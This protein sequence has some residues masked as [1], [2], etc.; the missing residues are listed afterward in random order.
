MLMR[1][2]RCGFLVIFGVAG[3]FLLGVP[4]SGLP[5]DLGRYRPMAKPGGADAITRSLPTKPGPTAAFHEHIRPYLSAGG[6]AALFGREK[7]RGGAGPVRLAPSPG[8]N[9]AVNDPTGQVCGGGCAQSEESIAVSGPDLVIGFNDSEGFLDPTQG[10]SGYSYSS[11]GGASWTD[12]GGLSLAGGGDRLGGDPA[13][14]FCGGA[15]YYS[16]LYLTGLA[17]CTSSGVTVAEAE[18]NDAAATA[19]PVA[20]GDD[21][22]GTISS[23]TDFD[24]VSFFAPAGT[25]LSATTVL[26]TLPDS[27][28]GLFAPD[29]TTLLAVNDDANGT[30]ASQINYLITTAGTYYLAVVGFGGSTGTYA[31]Q[32]RSCAGGTPGGFSAIAVSKGT[33][34]GSVLH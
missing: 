16:S 1:D 17:G 19:N 9:L 25:N 2:R 18:S 30:L 8:V 24:Y 14:T 33:F 11:N 20:L 21:F 31:L 15:F 22:T 6:Y 3:T 28:L 34:A 27:I 23:E 10:N 29:G 26:G 32:V 13:L 4:S 12:G 7:V 5:S